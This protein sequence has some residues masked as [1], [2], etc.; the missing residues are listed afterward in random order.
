MFA[1]NA[2]D[3]HRAVGLLAPRQHVEAVLRVTG[4]RTASGRACILEWINMKRLCV[5]VFL[6]A[7]S[8]APPVDPAWNRS[9]LA[10]GETTA[11]EAFEAAKELGTPAAWNAFLAS[12]PNG[13]YADLARAYLKNLAES[14]GGAAAAPAATPVPAGSG[15]APAETPKVE[16]GANANL[17]GVRL[18]P[19]DSPWYRDISKAPVD[20][21]SAR[22]LAR[23]G[24]KPLHPDFGPVWEGVPIG[25]PYIVVPGTQK[26]VPVAFKDADESD[27]GPYPIPP[28]A[29]IEGGPN[30]DGDR[31]VLVLDRDNWILYEIFN[32]F[33]ERSGA[34]KADSGAVWDLKK[35]QVRP[36][37][38]TSADAAGLPILPGLVRYDEVVGAQAVEHAL[39]F[40]LA[41]SRRAY[42]P[43]ASHW[44]S[45]SF[46]E[47][48]PPM[49]MRVR[50]KA[51]YDISGFAP[52][53]QVILRALKKYGMIL[54]DNGSDNFLSGAPDP[55]WDPD[56]LRQLKRVTT[57]DLEVV[58]MK[59]MVVDRRR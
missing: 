17:N 26:K 34:W 33:P 43:P 46:D 38:W 9:A 30:G 54:A 16:L 14:G 22:I 47:T 13:F 6:V 20:R 28:D 2:L 40:T 18:L 10:Q 25:I 55:R 35:N 7:A 31:H 44:A 29:P 21:N 49:G 37:R 5:A 3:G 12:F 8:F 39:R 15:S 4:A 59:D 32:A 48:L 51:G 36:D 27:P 45:D 50:L 1:G 53:V 41:K 23:V 56:I 42:V 57:K 19:D 58:E 52:Q 24:N 11:R